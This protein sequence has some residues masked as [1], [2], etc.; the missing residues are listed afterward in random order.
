MW[1]FTFYFSMIY[2][3]KNEIFLWAFH[4]ALWDTELYLSDV[5]R[6]LE[7]KIPLEFSVS[8]KQQENFIGEAFYSESQLNPCSIADGLGALCH[9]HGF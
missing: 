7:G 5:A 9:G 3:K 6:T 2:S 1:D 4:S 8:W